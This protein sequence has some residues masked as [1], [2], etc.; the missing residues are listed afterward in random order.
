[1]DRRQGKLI[2]P[3]P[4]EKRPKSIPLILEDIEIIRGLPLAFNP[5]MPFFRNESSSGGVQLGGFGS[6]RLYRAWKRACSRLKIHGV[7][8][9]GGTKHS[10]AMAAREY[11]TFEEVRLMTGHTTN[12]PFERYFR[13]E[14]EALQILYAKRESA[15]QGGEASQVIDFSRKQWRG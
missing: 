3:R 6:P 12:K 9:Y 2:I 13:T 1:M 11:A 14:G 5:A 7:D 8:L 15:L 4:K 10:T